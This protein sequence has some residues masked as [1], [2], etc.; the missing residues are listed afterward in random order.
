MDGWFYGVIMDDG[1]DGWMVT[2]LVRINGINYCWMDR[3]ID[4]FACNWG[5]GMNGWIEDGWGV[6]DLWIWMDGWM[7]LHVIER[8]KW[9]DGLRMD[10]M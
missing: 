4:G 1:M 9:M 2:W 7:D 5:D 6:I 3:W 10:E 8:I